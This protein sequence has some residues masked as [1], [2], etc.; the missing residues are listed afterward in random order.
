MDPYSET[1][2]HDS[3]QM[4]WR[5]LLYSLAGGCV[6]LIVTLSIVRGELPLEPTPM[7][8]FTW[9]GLLVGVSELVIAYGRSDRIVRAKVVEQLRAGTA[10][11]D[12]AVWGP[13]YH[14]PMV[15]RGSLFTAATTFQGI[16]YLFD[17]QWISL[18]FAGVLILLILTQGTDDHAVIAW[19][20][21]QQRQ[22]GAEWERPKS[23]DDL[24]SQ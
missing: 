9:V 16:A 1:P 3:R 11:D 4:E 19:V 5:I 22:I 14:T 20:E 6:L 10:S 23:A 12:L 18:A 17:G 7:Y 21:K 15:L 2:P 24:S 8:I 13:I